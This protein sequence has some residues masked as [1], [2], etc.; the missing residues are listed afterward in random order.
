MACSRVLMDASSNHE[1]IALHN[2]LDLNFG[3]MSYDV[4]NVGAQPIDR[5]Q[6]QK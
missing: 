1:M 2:E 4:Y 6:P 5:L 3:E